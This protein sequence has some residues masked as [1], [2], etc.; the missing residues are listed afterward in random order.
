MSPQH[1]VGRL[2]WRPQNV[3]NR[4]DPAEFEKVFKTTGREVLSMF[5]KQIQVEI[6]S[7][8]RPFRFNLSYPPSSAV[9]RDKSAVV[10]EPAVGIAGCSSTTPEAWH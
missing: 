4:D 9:L 2:W 10:S 7:L 5:F 3:E 6:P 8:F 1:W